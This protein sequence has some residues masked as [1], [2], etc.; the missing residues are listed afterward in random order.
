[1]LMK[2]F[3][4]A[5]LRLFLKSFLHFFLSVLTPE[6]FLRMA[7]DLETSLEGAGFEP[8]TSQFRADSDK[9]HDKFK[10]KVSGNTKSF[11]VKKESKNNA[12]SKN[13]PQNVI[14]ELQILA[15]IQ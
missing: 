15:L 10:F 11:L 8:R 2:L 1:M 9:G 13:L 14:H 4:A 6:N 7:G 12:L 3:K 5:L